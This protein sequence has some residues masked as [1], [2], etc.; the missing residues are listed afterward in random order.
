MINYSIAMMGNP[1]KPDDPKKAYGVAQYTEKMTLEKFSEHISDHNNVYDAEDVQAILGKAVKCLR[2]MLLAGKKVELG[3]LGEFYVTL[4]GKGTETASKYNPDICVEKVNVVWVPGKSFEN[5][6]ENAVF[7]IVANRDEQRAAIRRA[8]AQGDANPTDPAPGD[9][10][11]KGDSGSTGQ[12]PSEG[13]SGSQAGGSQG[14][15]SQAGGS[16]TGGG[17]SSSGSDSGDENVK[18][19]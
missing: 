14:G 8:K 11:G 16:Q 12:K 13:G 4:Q 15:G 1:A 3:K 5:L 7:N 18:E 9:S 6:K 17:S 10:E 19:Y 2:E